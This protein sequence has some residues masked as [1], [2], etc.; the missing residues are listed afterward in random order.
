MEASTPFLSARELASF[1]DA[2]RGI[3]LGPHALLLWYADGTSS[4]CTRSASGELW[5]DRRSPEGSVSRAGPL[6][7][8]LARPFASRGNGS[9]GEPSGP[10]DRLLAKS[11]GTV[12]RVHVSEG[13]RVQEGALLLTLE[14]M[15]ME[16]HVH[17]PRAATIAS[18]HV[19]P[20]QAVEKGA[21]LVRFA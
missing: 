14:L 1:P 16:L 6:A 4:L 8:A 10:Q 15:K 3:R 11:A 17:A 21:L 12:A 7:A 2:V 5:V 20:G 9:Q 13:E 18:L 19:G